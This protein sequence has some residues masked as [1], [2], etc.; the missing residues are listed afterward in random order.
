MQCIQRW[1][2]ATTT[3]LHLPSAGPL[4]ETPPAD[5]WA[6]PQNME[7]ILSCSRV[8]SYANNPGLRCRE[9]FQ[10]GSSR[11]QWTSK[12][13]GLSNRPLQRWSWR[14][15]RDQT[16]VSQGLTHRSN[17]SALAVLHEQHLLLSHITLTDISFKAGHLNILKN[18]DFSP[19][20]LSGGMFL[21]PRLER[22]LQEGGDQVENAT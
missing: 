19:A 13:L 15:L 12:T 5:P 16:S 7:V 3:P 18:V 14:L 22:L 9:I 11:V 10:A 8:C 2:S 17:I 4:H 1:P 21:E 6:G 20:V